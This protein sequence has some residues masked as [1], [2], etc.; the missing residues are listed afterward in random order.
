MLSSPK[1]SRSIDVNS[2]S[3]FFKKNKLNYK[4]I[5]STTKALLYAKS[6]ANKEDLIFVGGSSFLVS[7]VF[8]KWGKRN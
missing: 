5:S 6:I 8:K 3:I 4:I 1:V 2:L 7:E